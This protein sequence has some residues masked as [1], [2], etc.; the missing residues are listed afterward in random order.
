MIE[1]FRE[2]ES[3]QADWIE[4][5]LHEMVLGYKRVVITPEQARQMLGR[6]HT[7]PAIKK[8]ERITSGKDALMVLLIELEGLAREWRAFQGDWCYVDDKGEVC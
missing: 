5:E 7:L 3:A 4:A 6:Q 1:V 8:G 2:E